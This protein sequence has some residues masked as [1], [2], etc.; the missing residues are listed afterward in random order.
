MGFISNNGAGVV[1]EVGKLCGCRGKEV[2]RVLEHHYL[3]VSQEWKESAQR[4]A[5]DSVS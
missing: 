3:D 1:E 2:I 5:A 4:T